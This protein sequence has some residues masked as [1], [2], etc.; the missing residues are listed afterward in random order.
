MSLLM[1]LANQLAQF[2]GVT[3]CHG[4]TRYEPMTLYCDFAIPTDITSSNALNAKNSHRLTLS[5]QFV[6]VARVGDIVIPAI[7]HCNTVSSSAL[8]VPPIFNLLIFP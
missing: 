8:V 5:R 6:L 7:V 3:H 4:A 2:Y 1:V